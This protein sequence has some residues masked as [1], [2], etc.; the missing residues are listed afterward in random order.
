VA[1]LGAVA[2]PERAPRERRRKDDPALAEEL[3][4]HLVRD[5]PSLRPTDEQVFV[6][7]DMVAKLLLGK[8]QLRS[9]KAFKVT[10][11]SL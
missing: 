6:R 9:C 5:H 8:V 2:P 1:T 11:P 10:D 3:R 7:P 4:G